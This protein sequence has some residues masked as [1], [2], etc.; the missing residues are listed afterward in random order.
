[1]IHQ[2][3]QFGDL[4]SLRKKLLKLA[5]SRNIFPE[6]REDI[7]QQTF[8]NMCANRDKFDGKNVFHW[9]CTIL[10]NAWRDEIVKNTNLRHGGQFKAVSMDDL[11]P[12]HVPFAPGDP[13]TLMHCTQVMRVLCRDVPVKLRIALSHNVMGY[14]NEE[15]AEMEDIPVATV[16]TRIHRGREHMRMAFEIKS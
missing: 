2:D 1:M 4:I 9:A 11:D 14:T 15:I 7:V 16:K 10:L 5:A 3:Y 12:D 8:I 6:L 13:E